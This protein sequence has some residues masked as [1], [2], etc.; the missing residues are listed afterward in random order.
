MKKI[1]C[2]IC[3]YNEAP[4]IEKVL[5]VAAVHPL[6]DEV[7]VVDDGSTD[8]T[9]AVAKKVKGVKVVTLKKNCGKT[10][11]LRTGLE[12]VKNE[13]VLLLDADLL[14]LHAEDLT[15]LIHP[16][17]SGK[18]GMSLSLRKNSFRI[19]KMLGFDFSSGERVF[20]KSLLKGHLEKLRRLP[21][22]GFEV[23][24][25]DLFIQT[26]QVLAVAWWPTVSHVR[27]SKKMGWLRGQWSEIKMVLDMARTIGLLKIIS[28]NISLLRLR[29]RD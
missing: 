10:E 16:V 8:A 28:Q 4:R 14:G 12:K 19:H 9:S 11:A 29:A 17:L 1:S 24:L 25:N 23:F 2:L 22:F 3:A 18:A 7:L 6:V 5:K 20:H 15:A 26:R 13:L 27:K 21:R